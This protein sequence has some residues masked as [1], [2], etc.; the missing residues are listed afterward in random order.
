MTATDTHRAI[1]AVFRVESARLIG[2]ISCASYDKPRD[3]SPEDV[4]LLSSVANIIALGSER[5][6]RLRVEE[7]LRKAIVSKP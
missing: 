1:E 5:R 7:N 4:L 2:A 6:R 3:W